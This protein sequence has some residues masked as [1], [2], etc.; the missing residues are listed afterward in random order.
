MALEIDSAGPYGNLVVSYTV[1]NTGTISLSG[2]WQWSDWFY[3]SPNPVLDSAATQVASFDES[4]RLAAGA[5]YRRTNL[6]PVTGY[7]LVGQYLYLNADAADQLDETNPKNNVLGI[8]ADTRLPDL[9][10][11]SLSWSGQAIA[12]QPISVTYSVTNRGTLD[13]AGLAGTDV[14]LHDGFY[15]STKATWDTTAIAI[16]AMDFSGTVPAGAGYTH[17]NVAYLEAGAPGNYWLLLRANDL[18]LVVESDTSNNTLAVPVSLA[19]PDLVPLS[20]TAPVGAASDAGVQIVYTVTNQ[21]N[22]AALG[23]WEDTLYLSTNAVWDTS[24][25]LLGDAYQQGPVPAQGSYVGTN[26]VL[27]P[28]WAAGTYYLIL[29]ADSYGMF[30]QATNNFLAVPVTLLAPAGLPDLVPLSVVAPASA[31]SGAPLEV[32]YSVTNSGRATAVGS[33][34]DELWLSTSPVWDSTADVVGLQFVRGPVANGATYT[35]TN[36]AAIP[37]QV[38]AGPYYLILQV[39]AQDQAGEANLT[40]KYLATAIQVQPPGLTPGLAVAFLLAPSSARPGQSIQVAYAVT[41]LGASAVS[42]PWFDALVLSTDTTLSGGVAFLALWPVLGPVPPGGGY[43][44]TNSV[45]LPDVALGDYY[46]VL[47]VDPAGN[48]NGSTNVMAVPITLQQSVAPTPTPILLNRAAELPNGAFQ[49]TFTNTPGASFT[50]FSTTNLFLPFSLW[51]P[52]GSVPEVSPGSFQ[53]ADL[54]ATRS[55]PHFYRVRSP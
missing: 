25:Y 45:A 27:L 28:G 23:F 30:D 53:F 38:A 1:T 42:G 32:V 6:V 34:L 24:A 47:A 3:L 13:I 55:L 44:S 14:E 43:A 21:G 16:G 35:E 52:L 22:A 4:Q 39:D 37:P 18:G 12:G 49:F 5:V 11:S 19:A 8:P 20:I 17:T 41:N 51:T 48:P 40:N 2:Q 7:S 31:F 15:V 29:Q 36:S 26:S 10:P 54:P 33:W 50:V 46:L 9:V